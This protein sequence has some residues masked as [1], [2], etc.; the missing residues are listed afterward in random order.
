MIL[1]GPK[2][3]QNADD[4]LMLVKT[5][6]CPEITVDGARERGEVHAVVDDPDLAWR[7]AELPHEI[8]HLSVRDTEVGIGHRVQGDVADP[9]QHTSGLQIAT[10]VNPHDD[11]GDSAPEPPR[12]GRE[13]R[14][15]SR[16]P[17]PRRATPPVASAPGR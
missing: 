4:E 5:E 3:S 1:L 15:C 9:P 17:P 14:R 8:G 10:V 6:L 11:A 2:G 13:P 16:E 7:I 12:P